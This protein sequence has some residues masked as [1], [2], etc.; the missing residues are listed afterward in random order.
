MSL[1]PLSPVVPSC[2]HVLSGRSLP[3]PVHLQ[4]HT[5]DTAAQGN[6]CWQSHRQNYAMRLSQ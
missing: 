6:T 2:L 5:S 1:F 3:A 4:V